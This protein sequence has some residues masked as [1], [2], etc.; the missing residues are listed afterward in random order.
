MTTAADRLTALSK[1]TQALSA[2]PAPDAIPAAILEAALHLAQAERGCLMF[3]DSEKGELLFRLG[4]NARGETLEAQVF[5]AEQSLARETAQSR[6]AAAAAN[7]LTIPLAIGGRVAG[8]ICLSGAAGD[9]LELL[10]IF[11]G[12]AAAV[13]ENLRLQEALQQTQASKNKFVSVV[14]H[15]LK[16][17][18]T[19]IK[20]Y[21]D[22][23]LQGLVGPLTE[24]QTQF[25]SIIRANVE[26][27]A[28]LVNDLADIS[29]IETGRIKLE[30][31]VLE[32]ADSAEA[33]LAALR[34]QIEAK[35][36]TLIVHLPAGLPRVYADKTR[37]TQILTNLLGNAH[38]Y[39]L[40]G[41][42][43]TL[44]AEVL[45]DRPFVRVVVADTGIGISAEDQARLF[46]PFFRSEAPHVREQT[47]WGL[48][49]HLTRLFVELL[50]GQLTFHSELDRGSA[51]A[52]TV[53]I[54]LTP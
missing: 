37:L 10:N 25:L 6:E 5:E 48:A 16:I 13:V 44:S 41:G 34:P 43:I 39:T 26:R 46:T 21:A 35:G 33:A 38:K 49:L 7:S 24:Q 29:R 51:F 18:M 8:V 27:M 40:A 22:L 23:M 50:G 45:A 30:L 1:A 36:Q 53:P 54:A 42:N 11:A 15:E 52:F 28:A 3:K 47:G 2:A 17:P 14:T 20:G 31:D 9:R 12:Q 19:P 4:C 32:L